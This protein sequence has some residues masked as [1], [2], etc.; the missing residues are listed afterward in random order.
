[1]KNYEIKSATAEYT[2]GGIYVY[3]GQFNDGTWFKSS[4][5]WE[6]VEICNA[7]TSTEESDYCEFYETHL[8][9]SIEGEAYKELFNKI[10]QWIIDNAPQGN[11]QAYELEGRLLQERLADR[12]L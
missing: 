9:E 3:Y 6:S 1:M 2:G 12:M 5:C 7:D 4:D 8:I 11:Y 10:I